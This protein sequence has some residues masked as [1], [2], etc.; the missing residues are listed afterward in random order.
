L[1]VILS[2]TYGEDLGRSRTF[3]ALLFLNMQL[4]TQV[5]RNKMG[6]ANYTC[7]GVE[8]CTQESG[9]EILRKETIWKTQI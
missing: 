5:K 3:P 8:R 7:C 1:A 4:G 9:A 2:N 6:G